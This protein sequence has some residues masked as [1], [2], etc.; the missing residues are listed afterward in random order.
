MINI[1]LIS[2][3]VGVFIG[4][5][6]LLAGIGFA[7][8][9]FVSGGDKYK[10]NLI[11]TL[12]ESIST[13]EEKNKKQVEERTV[14]ISSHQAQLTQ[15][16]KDFSELKGRFEEQAKTTEQYRELLQGRDPQMLETLH[17]IKGFMKSMSIDSKENQTRNKKI[18]KEN[19]KST[20]K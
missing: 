11:E 8:A 7:Y 20:R 2:T 3:I 19:K 1:E 6:A 14:L 18:D 15:L 16:T 17:E 9:Q 10:D 12:K 13:L 5:G 4:L